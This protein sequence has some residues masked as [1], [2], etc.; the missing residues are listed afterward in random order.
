MTDRWSGSGA[1]KG[2]DYDRHWAAMAERGESVHGE[3]DL[4]CSLVPTPLS[5]LDAGCGTGRI[6]IELARRGL[7]V[8]GVDVDP[9]M[10]EQ[11]RAKAPDLSWAE[12]DLSTWTTDERFDLVLLAGNVLLFVAPGTEAA[13]VARCADHLADG[14]AVVAGFSLG[15]GFSEADL[16]AAAAAVG[17]ALEHRW[18]TWDRAPFVPGA[19]DYAVSVLRRTA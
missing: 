6:A 1:A 9:T 8:A 17:L 7:Q 16:D 13:V 4:V 18:S 5:V 2:A 19:S 14:G 12:G 10:L 11:A 15:R 3:A